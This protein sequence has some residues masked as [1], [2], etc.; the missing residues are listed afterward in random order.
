MSQRIVLAI[1]LACVVSSCEKKPGGQTVAVVNNEE[2]TAADLNAE[3][4]NANV[5]PADASKDVRSRALESL[6]DRRLLAQ[7]AKA[8]GIDKS[9]EFLSRERRATEDLLINMLVSRQTKTQQ[10]PSASDI[11]KYE[12]SRPGMFANR[13]LWNLQ[14]IIYPLSKDAA[15]NA[16]LA[17]SKSLDEIAQI[18]TAAGIQFTRET[19]PFDS[20]L[21]PPNVYAQIAH[22]APGEPFIAPGVDKAVASAIESRQTVPLN[23]DQQRQLALG[24][25]QRDRVNQVVSQRVKE[26]KAKAKIEYGP[27]FAPPKS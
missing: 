1:I 25:L 23:P 26:L 5:S 8:D 24:Q 4:N 20:A 10:V 9:P 16:K 21:L 22:L 6:I 18:L 11:A 13:E 19:K 2:I 27:G 15:V 3:L 7:Q 14:Q 12:A 17:A